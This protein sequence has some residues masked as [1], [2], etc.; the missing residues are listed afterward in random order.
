MREA[1][2]PSVARSVLGRLRK[3]EKPAL[4][5]VRAVAVS[6]ERLE[7]RQVAELARLDAEGFGSAH[8]EA[9]GAGLLDADRPR[10]VH[11]LV[12]EAVRTDMPA[13]QRGALH[14][15]AADL[16]ARDGGEA[17]SIAAT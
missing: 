14:R 16:L 7:T 15:R 13:L 3:L 12:A 4:A 1:V 9:A 10:F 17:D 6:G 2:P 5:L 11:P 8:A